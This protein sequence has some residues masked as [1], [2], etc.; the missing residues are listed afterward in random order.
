MAHPWSG[1]RFTRKGVKHWY[2]TDK[3]GTTVDFFEFDSLA[4]P[5]LRFGIYDQDE[6]DATPGDNRVLFWDKDGAKATVQLNNQLPGQVLVL[7]NGAFFG[8]DKKTEVSDAFHLSPVVLR[9]KALY[10]KF[11]HRWTFGVKYVD[12]KPQWNVFFKPNQAQLE[13]S[14]DFAAGSVQCL[15]KDGKPLPVEPFPA[16]GQPFKQQ[17]V[18]STPLEAGHIPG[19]DHMLSCRIS[20]AW[21]RDGRYLYWL[22]IKEQDDE[23]SS[24]MAVNERRYQPGGWTV[25]DVQRFWLS[26][27]VWA[28]INSD[29]GDAMQMTFARPGGG[30]TYLPPEFVARNTMRQNLDDQLKGAPQQGGALMYYYVYEKRN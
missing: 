25:A 11:N 18:P 21:S 5:N 16:P 1:A 4:N 2:A 24:I 22:A 27:G 6:D 7:S 12:G 23:G 19:F 3:D 20:L 17:P 29:A 28:A 30:Y 9:G 15:V 13:K 8:Y 14:F 10:T 26:K